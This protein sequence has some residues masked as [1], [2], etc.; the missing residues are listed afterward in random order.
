[1]P[2]VVCV[3]VPLAL[4][5]DEKVITGELTGSAMVAMKWMLKIVEKCYHPINRIET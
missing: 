3:M 2:F 4:S 5:R 1:M